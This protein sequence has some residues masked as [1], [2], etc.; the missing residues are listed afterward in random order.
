MS[1]KQE[2]T[3][4]QVEETS[5]ERKFWDLLWKGPIV[6]KDEGKAKEK[7]KLNTETAD[8]ENEER[9]GFWWL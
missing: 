3:E 6:E 2:A 5:S 8:E 4:N 1:N 9:K 7:E